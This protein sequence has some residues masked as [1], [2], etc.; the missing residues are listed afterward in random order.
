MGKA[1]TLA[2]HVQSAKSPDGKFIA[3][4]IWETHSEGFFIIADSYSH[5]Q[6][7]ILTLRTAGEEEPLRRIVV[8]P[9]EHP[10]GHYTW[11]PTNTIVW[12]EDSEDVTFCLRDDTTIA[13]RIAR[14][15]NGEQ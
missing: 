13:V 5:K 9:Y 4:A 7:C 3:R 1:D 2:Q 14:S 6:R 10:Y 12:S 15:S 8:E 11:P